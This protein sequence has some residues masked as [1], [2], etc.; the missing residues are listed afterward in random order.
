[1]AYNA[2]PYHGDKYI[3]DAG[4]SIANDISQAFDRWDK[5]RKDLEKADQMMQDMAQRNDP[6]TGEPMIDPDT[7]ERWRQSKHRAA[8]A[9]G[10]IEG[11]GL[12]DKFSQMQGQ[13]EDRAREQAAFNQPVASY[14]GE[15][16]VKHY[17]GIHTPKTS[18]TDLDAKGGSDRK[19]T[20]NM[21]V[22][23]SSKEN[24]LLSGQLKNWPNTVGL[25]QNPEQLLDPKNPFGIIDP[26]T[27]KFQA[28]P[29]G[30]TQTH[31][32]VGDNQLPIDQYKTLQQKA[33]RIMDNKKRIDSIISNQGN[34]GNQGQTTNRPQQRPLT[35]GIPV[36]R[37]AAEA[38]RMIA[39]GV[40]RYQ[41][42]D[43]TVYNA[44]TQPQQQGSQYQP[45]ISPVRPAALAPSPDEDTTDNGG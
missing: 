3:S 13:N 45:G 4:T 12:F 28:T 23:Q 21:I 8:A 20:P 17:V 27:G 1:M 2:D 10:I 31:V 30:S 5:N 7:Y 11:M 32:Q 35:P 36:A 18:V 33:Q 38:Q 41:T 42:P 43:G 15:D 34:Q 24:K 19:V 14:T 22:D 39:N 40:Q 9:Q 6:V 25:E 44:G 26:K 16:G 29:Q 37:N